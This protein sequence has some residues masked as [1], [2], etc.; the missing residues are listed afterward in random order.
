MVNESFSLLVVHGLALVFFADSS[1]ERVVASL[2]SRRGMRIVAGGAGVREASGLLA[3]EI[4]D[5]TQ[6]AASADDR[7]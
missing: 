5:G 6:S 3:A 1:V 2:E 4:G 7:L